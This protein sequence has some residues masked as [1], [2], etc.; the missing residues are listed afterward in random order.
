MKVKN[1]SVDREPISERLWRTGDGKVSPAKPVFRDIHA[2]FSIFLSVFCRKY[3]VF[4]EARHYRTLGMPWEDEKWMGKMPY[5]SN[6]IGAK[7]DNPS[8]LEFSLPL[9]SKTVYTIISN[10]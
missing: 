5:D 2:V 9:F 4:F 6:S 10:R 8:F 7:S 3:A 1:V